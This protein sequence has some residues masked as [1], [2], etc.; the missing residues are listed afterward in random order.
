VP[1]KP[2]LVLSWNVLVR[3][4]HHPRSREPLLDLFGATRFG[5]LF[6]LVGI[7]RDRPALAEMPW[8]H[9]LMRKEK[10]FKVGHLQL[11]GS[12]HNLVPVEAIFA[13]NQQYR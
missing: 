5:P 6:D 4:R 13:F 2:R 9:V 11:I 10:P 12:E 7:N 3:L 8:L 1:L